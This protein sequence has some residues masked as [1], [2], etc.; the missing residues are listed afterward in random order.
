MIIFIT[1]LNRKSTHV[2]IKPTQSFGN[3]NQLLNTSGVYQGSNTLT[4]AMACS[5]FDVSKTNYQVALIF[6]RLIGKGSDGFHG[7]FSI[8]YCLANNESFDNQLSKILSF[9]SPC[10][11]LPEFGP[12]SNG[13]RIFEFSDNPK[14]GGGGCVTTLL[15]RL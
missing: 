13:S 9:F 10:S 11:E 5:L 6:F 8:V 2:M 15:G 4:I 1:P 14:L 7:Y 3:H 12:E